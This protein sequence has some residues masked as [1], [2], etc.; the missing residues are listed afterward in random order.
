LVDTC[1]QMFD[2]HNLRYDQTIS[3]EQFR[4]WLKN[5]TEAMKYVDM[6]HGSYHLPEIEQYLASL[7]QDQAVI[8]VQLCPPGEDGAT[9]NV[10]VDVLWSS[11]NLRQ[12]MGNPSKEIFEALM[13]MMTTIT[14]NFADVSLEHFVEVVHSWNVFNVVDFERSGALDPKELKVLMWLQTRKEPTDNVVTKM[15]E[16]FKLGEDENAFISRTA[17]I[18]AN[19]SIA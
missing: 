6:Y 12:A 3:K 11:N 17:W 13:R 10:H 16:S 19:S 15:R 5:T 14:S 8:F 7:E 1:H 2:S 18:S 4:R 9:K